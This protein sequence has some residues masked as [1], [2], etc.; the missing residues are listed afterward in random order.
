MTDTAEQVKDA[1]L[2]ALVDLA[3]RRG[4][5]TEQVVSEPLFRHY[6]DRVPP[7]DLSA[8][9][10]IDLYGAAVRHVQL[11][12]RRQP[13]ESLVRIY[14]P[15]SDEDGWTSSHTVI[16]IVGADMP[17]IVDSVLALLETQGLQVHV[18]VHPMVD[19][20]RSAG[21]DL[22][23]IAP[24]QNGAPVESLLH[25][26]IDRVSSE[27]QRTELDA[28][29]HE[30]L[31]DVR[32]AV[33]DWMAMRAKAL[34]L[35]D[36]L[37]GW[38]R[39]AA[40]GSARFEATVGTDP[41]ETAALLRWMEAGSFTFVG[42]RGYDFVDDPDHPTI[43]SIPSTGLGT[44]RQS[45]AS[46]RDLGE[47]P[48][49]TAE[50]ARRPTVLNL[51]KANTYSTVHRA[52]PLDYVGIKRIDPDGT[53]TGERRFIGLFTSTVYT[54]RVE[55]IPIVRAKVAA[56]MERTNFQQS[57][58]DHSRLLNTLQLYPRDELFQADADVLAEMALDILDLRDRRQVSLLLRRDSFG[59]F[60]S[61]M[62]FV[63]RDRH[64]TDVRLRIQATLMEV[65]K[66]T[67]CRFS[68][69]ISDAPL[70]RLHLVIYTDPT[71]EDEL[72]DPAAVQARLAQVT[73]TWD[74]F[75]RDALI[76]TMG[77]DRGLAL[78]SRYGQAF[79]A[80][81][82]SNVLAESAVHDIERL[83]ALDDN[84]LDVALHRPLEARR[85][86]LRCKLYRSGDP[87]T[88]TQF[89]PVLHDLGA[90]VTDERPYEVQRG[91]GADA[92]AGSDRF[93]YD[94]GLRLGTELDRDARIRFS[95]AVL[96]VWRGDAE[97]DRLARLVVTAG[98]S[99]RDVTVLRAYSRYLIQIGSRFSP[100]YVMDTLNQSPNVA[101]L[102]VELFRARFDPERAGSDEAPAICAEL[103]AAIDSVVS[104]D[105]DRILRLF[106]AVIG[107]TSRTNYW[108]QGEDGE[109]R[110]ALA[111]KLDPSEIPGVPKPLPAAEIWV[112]SPR[113]EGVHL[114][115][116]RVARGGL[117][118]S[119]RMEDFRTEILGLMKAQT[120]KNS[121]IVPVGAK[122]GFVARELP[123]GGTR[124]AVMA[125]VVGCYKIFIGAL[126]DVTDNNVGGEVVGPPDV[127]RHD[128]DDP[129]MVVAADKG[130]ATFS[131]TANAIAEE[132]DFWLGDA[133]ASGG[134]VGYDHKALG[135]T[136]R[137]AW[138][139]VERHFRELGV[140]VAATEFTAVGVGDM[141]G[142]VFGNGMLR[143]DKTRLVAAF[144]HRHVFVDPDPDPAVSFAERQR[145]YD[146][147]RSS[148]VDYDAS[149]IST[150]GG[151]F[152]RDAKSI[153]TTP[154]MI[155]VLGLDP[156]IEELTPDEL[157]AAVLRAPVDLLWNGGIGTYV[158]ASSQTDVE[159]GDRSNDSVR[160][161]A[162][163][164]RC[165]VIGEGGNL[166]VSQLGRVEFSTLG[167]LI[168][169]DAIDNSAGVDCSDHE[170]NLKILLSL[171]ER[172]GDLTRKQ[173]N[174]VL[175]SMADDVCELV[176]ENNYVQNETLAAAKAQA[177]GMV[178]VHQ[179]L[180]A[181]LENE[182]GL[183]R[184]VEAL[185]TD[186]KLHARRSKGR[187][188]TT[189]ELAVVL[190]HTKNLVTEQ[191]VD[192]DLA[193]DPAFEQRLL[194]YFP[195]RIRDE[196]ADLVAQH[197]LR[198]ELIA[199]IVANDVVNRGGMTMIH[200]LI[201]ETSATAADIARA[202]TAAWRIFDLDPLLHASRA[203]DNKV[204]ASIQT[205]LNL[206]IR[207][208]AE[209]A[210]RW[211]LRNE[212]QPLDVERVVARYR[213]AVEM[214]H[215]ETIEG[216]VPDDVELELQRY[217]EGGVPR[218][219]AMGIAALGPAFGFLDLSNV[220]DRTQVALPDVATIHAAVDEH[221]GLSWLRER[222]IGL[223]RIDHWQTMARSALRD[224]FFREHAS[225]TESV[226][227]STNDEEAATTPADELVVRWLAANTVAAGRC[228]R[229]FADIEASGEYDLAHA[230]V[231]VRA[232][233]QLSRTA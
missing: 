123:L 215:V 144:D 230:S 66:G 145:L 91:A 99:W 201:E 73:R 63:P 86:E 59:R 142:D 17:F 216:E 193:Q 198:T 83:E 135:I 84:S 168:N 122:G 34:E 163:D 14:N 129:Y 147:P 108:Q 164:L 44:L 188:L 13:T 173:R 94:I 90:V 153:S 9:D 138:L 58:H 232:L 160:V 119:D 222:I 199:M 31:D 172:S 179:R 192:S 110:P 203:L 97:S 124:E 120:A 23:V 137:G 154:E 45:E 33:E 171:A 225:V 81:Y 10:P 139:S 148:W 185:P 109:H 212:P 187:G 78:L 53:V 29:V 143:S 165:K 202:H 181:W 35:A 71:P 3:A 98:L 229:T 103:L 89:I 105:A 189:P 60:L 7:Q 162:D 210:T 26:E 24:P 133:F 170:V 64:S 208:L 182:A 36:E 39:E 233:S 178:Q 76:E 117:R 18:L 69:E 77:E 47:L 115:S 92:E 134:S 79:D 167:G 227:R 96:A 72:P 82:V 87:I 161:D 1:L 101:R 197:P 140:D 159:I 62:V 200:R 141:S 211:L 186:S 6:F 220:A 48:P 214:L 191:L 228:R 46:V 68:T 51:T 190:A 61:C 152:A 49:E 38:A 150:G 106:V 111:F 50:R 149:L 221:L 88:L 195:P 180:M 155:D 131:D 70:A 223:P 217:V 121:V 132:R 22:L 56:V 218:E 15:N 130:T 21:G 114:R 205:D 209:R 146:L 102:L 19:V 156:E 231:A 40:E 93:I 12:E 32:A 128:G 174:Q 175:E 57:S 20:D 67:S 184:V 112:Y 16:D 166:G 42:Y 5:A 100:A 52:V 75:L 158:K 104:L 118:W 65:Y 27:D 136:A 41:V 116:G 8:K 28:A 11:A 95:D 2:D 107:G 30:V 226:L 151:V 25:I 183:E 207:R 126:L 74:D 54:D 169:N 219:L 125:E 196:F 55:D 85:D 157:I 127:V 176:L 37:E 43:R 113:T 194:E 206:A 213:D 224:E 80:S 204:A 4:H 177:P